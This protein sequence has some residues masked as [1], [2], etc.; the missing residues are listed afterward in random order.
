MATRA[1]KRLS[2]K[3][4]KA[5]EFGKH[6]D[7]DGLYLTV[8]MTGAARWLFVYRWKEL[9]HP[10]AGRIREMGLGP[11]IGG[12]TLPQ[13]RDK[14]ADARKQLRDGIDPIAARKV[15]VRIAPTFGEVADSYIETHGPGM[16]NAKHRD[17]W[18]MTVG[19]Q[20]EPPEGEKQTNGRKAA[21]RKQNWQGWEDEGRRARMR[22]FRK[23]R[24]DA[25]TPA[26]VL[27]VVKPLW[28]EIPESAARTRARIEKV[29]YAASA[30]HPLGPN[31]ALWKGGLEH[32]LGRR[33]DNGAHFPRLPYEALPAFFGELALDDA[34]S[35]KALAFLIQTAARTGEVLGATWSEFDLAAAIWTVPAARMKMGVEHRVPLSIG[36]LTI[37]KEIAKGSNREPGEYVFQGRAAGSPVSNMAMAMLMRRMGKGAFTPH[38]FRSSFRDWCGDATDY[39]RELAEQSLA[40]AIGDAVERAYRRGDAL[41]RRRPMMDAWGLYCASKP[42]DRQAAA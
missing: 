4:L 1:A 23:L 14:V 13:A 35:A 12:L 42:F 19:P 33:T 10:G 3:D 27:K 25:I 31:P 28:A 39:P 37:V 29:L 8:D 15:V 17:Q 2:G 38:G 18:A 32:H 30:M 21:G 34:N 22:A 9:G 24:V 36:A 11:L 26:D 5:L 40:H 41:E 7:G 20:V 16:K 6:A